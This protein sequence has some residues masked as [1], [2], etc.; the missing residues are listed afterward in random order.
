MY[1]ADALREVGKSLKTAHLSPAQCAIGFRTMKVLTDQGLDGETAEN[2]ISDTYN[3]CSSLGMAPS[4]VVTYI[5]AL[6]KFSDKIRLPQIEDRINQ[7]IA[8]KTE[9][10]KELQELGVE[11][12]FL[13][14]QRSA[15]EKGRDGTWR[16]NKKEKLL[17]RWSR[18][19]M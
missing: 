9:L 6:I 10:E 16:W 15:L 4:K 8:R 7:K 11:I 13:E 1:E 19:L 14:R 18:M 2:I 12:S 17:G 3:K 5:E